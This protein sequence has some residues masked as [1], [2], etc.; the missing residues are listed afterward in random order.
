MQKAYDNSKVSSQS[1]QVTSIKYVQIGIAFQ[2]KY[3][4]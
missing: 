2:L 3:Y 4:Q 1:S